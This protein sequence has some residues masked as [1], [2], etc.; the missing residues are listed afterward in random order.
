MDGNFEIYYE[1]EPKVLSYYSRNLIGNGYN[2]F[3]IFSLFLTGKRFE[4]DVLQ[5]DQDVIVEF[6]KPTCPSC[7][8]LS[9]AYESFAKTIL[10]IQDYIHLL[11]KKSETDIAPKSA[12]IEKYKIQNLEKFKNLRVCRYNIY[13]EVCTFDSTSPQ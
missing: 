1:S 5:N 6:F 11:E 3:F 4:S 8:V 12:L 9:I 2:I 10:E 7:S 13:N